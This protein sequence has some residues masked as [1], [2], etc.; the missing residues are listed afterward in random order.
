[1]KRLMNSTTLKMILIR[2]GMTAILRTLPPNGRE[3]RRKIQMLALLK[4]LGA[5]LEVAAMMRRRSHTSVNVSNIYHKIT[6]CYI[7][8]LQR[9]DCYYYYYIFKHQYSFCGKNLLLFNQ[10]RY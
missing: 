9:S 2:M 10:C 4:D 5:P 6:D 7:A 3:Q 1:M 8:R